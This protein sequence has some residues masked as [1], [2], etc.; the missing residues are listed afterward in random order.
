VL[1][2]PR[3]K[4][5]IDLALPSPQ[6]CPE[7][8]AIGGRPLETGIGDSIALDAE[9]TDPDGDEIAYR[10]RADAGRILEPREP[11]TALVC[12]VRGP[13]TVRLTITD[14]GGCQRGASFVVS[15]R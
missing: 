5:G 11:S 7:L 14:A 15:C 6:F 9:A 13:S 10:W 12:E 4:T 2:I 8:T 3:K 1:V